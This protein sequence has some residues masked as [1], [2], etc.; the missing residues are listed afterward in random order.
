MGDD[1]TGKPDSGGQDQATSMQMSL[2]QKQGKVYDDW[3]NMVKGWNKQQNVLAGTTLGMTKDSLNQ[4]MNLQNQLS[5]RQQMG[6]DTTMA[7]YGKGEGLRQGLRDQASQLQSAFA[8]GT[9]DPTQSYMWGSGR[10][11]LEDQYANAKENIM[12]ST[13]SGGALTAALA[14]TEM[15]RAKGLTDLAST[16]AQNDYQNMMNLTN[17]ALSNSQ[18]PNLSQ[19]MTAPGFANPGIMGVTQPYMGEG[20]SGTLS[21][22]Q[23]M[24]AAQNAQYA[25]NMSALGSA[26]GSAAGSMF[27]K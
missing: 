18:A 9:Y 21:S 11:M 26:A 4:Y 5:G 17:S 23:Q 14:D 22:L 10:N 8:G 7:E 3:W 20:S 13:P 16:I 19:Y 1:V 6:I 27:D 15:G 25:Q 24:Y 2:A 12:G